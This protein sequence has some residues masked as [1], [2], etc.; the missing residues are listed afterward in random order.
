MKRLIWLGMLLCTITAP[1]LAAPGS[2]ETVKASIQQKI[3][4]NG[5]PES[6]FSLAIVPNDEVDQSGA[7]S[8]VGHCANDTYKIVYTRFRDAQ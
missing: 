3:I 2:C 8:V 4:N 6:E 7:N 1:S 5:V